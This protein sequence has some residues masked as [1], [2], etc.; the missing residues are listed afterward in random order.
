MTSTFSFAQHQIDTTLK[1]YKWKLPIP[2]DIMNEINTM[3]HATGGGGGDFWGWLNCRLFSWMI[4]EYVSNNQVYLTE[5]CPEYIHWE[6]VATH[7][8]EN[9]D[10][11]EEG[12]R[13]D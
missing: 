12:K 13:N 7:Y 1:A 11:D 4:F 2:T 9:E 10:E 3:E 8:D 5:S 6:D